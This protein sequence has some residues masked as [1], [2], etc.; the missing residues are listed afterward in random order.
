MA[1]RAGYSVTV[2][3]AF[4]DFQTVTVAEK[5]IKVGYGKL[6]FDAECLLSELSRLE[7]G[8]FV[9][10]LYGSGFEAQPD[11]LEK[12]A[13]F[14]PLIGN[15]PAVV[16]KVKDAR[17]FFGTLDTLAI[18]HPKTLYKFERGMSGFLKK[19][20]NGSGGAHI[21]LVTCA[22]P[23]L[24]DNEYYQERINGWPVS[25][26]FVGNGREMQVIGFNEQ[27][28]SPSD[29]MPFRY[30]GAVNGVKLDANVKRQLIEAAEKLTL[31]YGLCGLNSL[32]AVVSS[33]VAQIDMV[34]VLE[35]NP[36]LSATID[37]YGSYGCN[38]IDRHVN[39]CLKRADLNTTGLCDAHVEASVKAHAIVYAL[40][41]IEIDGAFEWPDWAVDTPW[42]PDG[43]INIAAGEPICTVIAV[44]DSAENA[45]RIAKTR[46]ELILDYLGCEH[47][48]PS[49]LPE[50]ELPCITQ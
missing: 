20:S 1:A 38:L 24:L 50:R 10:F 30:G 3:D 27:W 41:P 12:V 35:V 45:K 14:V 17:H 32:D 18:A 19:R 49:M 25:I 4:L 48:D 9:G 16:A 39:V 33:D 13:D 22:Q 11:L 37:L 44:A 28:L 5:S 29:D 26:L 47:R 34:Y 15:H 21:S 42:Q 6:G 23:E 7:L 46:V 31:S 40:Q 36:R 2:M 43:L 8:G